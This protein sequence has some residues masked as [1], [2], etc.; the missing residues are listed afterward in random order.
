MVSSGRH[1]FPPVEQANQTAFGFYP[2]TS[3]II[4]H[5]K[6]KLIPTD[7]YSSPSTNEAYVCSKWRALQK[8]TAG[9]A[10]QR[11]TD[12]EETRLNKY[13]YDTFIV[14][15]ALRPL[16]KRRW[17]DCKNKSTKEIATG[18][19]LLEMTDKLHP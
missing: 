17:T 9:I 13:I 14:P 8:T 16:N 18:L 5:S 3:I 7:K 10:M 11:S 1:D 19:Y 2:E 6:I 15:K 12:C 4:A